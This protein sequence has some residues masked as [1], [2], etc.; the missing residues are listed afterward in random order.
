MKLYLITFQGVAIYY[1]PIQQ[2]FH[3]PGI[4]NPFE[5]LADCRDWIL[6][7]VDATLN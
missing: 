4:P 2:T 1:N 7:S 3:L 6:A 5:S